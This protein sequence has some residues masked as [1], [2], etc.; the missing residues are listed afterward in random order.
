MTRSLQ[1]TGRQTEVPHFPAQFMSSNSDPDP[2][3]PRDK[4][5]TEIERINDADQPPPPT[6]P[7]IGDQEPELPQKNTFVAKTKALLQGF[8]L[9]P[10]F[11]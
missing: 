7:P 11:K 6:E 3:D 8:V 9:P 4:R 10:L 5:P 2:T 1:N